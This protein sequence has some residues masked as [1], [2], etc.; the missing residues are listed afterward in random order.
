MATTFVSSLRGMRIGSRIT[1]MTGINVLVVALLLSMAWLGMSRMEH[2][3]GEVERL[4]EQSMRMETIAKRSLK[5]LLLAR[6]FLVE[7]GPETISQL[8]ILGANL[9]RLIIQEAEHDPSIA[10]S[11]DKLRED[12]KEF[13]GGFDEIYTLKR[14]L[15][16]EYEHLLQTGETIASYI[17]I[18]NANARG[19]NAYDL[20][21]ELEKANRWL[22]QAIAA[23]NRFFFAEE[24]YDVAENGLVTLSIFL[25][26]VAD[27]AGNSLRSKYLYQAGELVEEYLEGLKRLATGMAREKELAETRINAPQDEI[28]SVINSILRDNAR[29]LHA[30]G[31]ALR[32]E[33]ERATIVGL[34]LVAGLLV[35]SGLLSWAIGR[36]ITQPL[37]ALHQAVRDQ[38]EGRPVGTIPATKA[39]MS[40]RPWPAPC[41]ASSAC[42]PR[43]TPSSWTCRPPSGSS[44]GPW[45]ASATSWTT[46]ARGSCPSARTFWQTRSS[47]AS[48]GPS[49]AATTLP[50]PPW[51][52]C[53]APTI[54][55]KPAKPWL[56]TCGASSRSRTP[57]AGTCCS[58]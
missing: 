51:L 23:V 43:R 26:A 50:A 37:G 8:H 57:F 18:V 41:A 39:A 46:A 7:G 13:Q 34:S 53:S 22:H 35:F 15:A 11:T 9:E 47:A 25:P 55:M 2:R 24:Q 20:L 28:Q 40:F 17:A 58:R 29:Q 44:V 21:P 3:L 5:L 1:L 16:I 19:E 36:S 45:A 27:R 4:R 12:L 32:R 56:R 33:L 38:A 10:S 14:N 52:R 31:Q 6:Q 42:R 30:G 54:P 48:A 49:S